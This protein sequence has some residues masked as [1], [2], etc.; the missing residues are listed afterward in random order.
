[1]DREGGIGLLGINVLVF[2][3]V[4][5][6]ATGLTALFAS[7]LLAAIIMFS[8]FSFLAVLIYLMLGAP[9]VAFTEA[10]VGVVATTFLIVALKRMDRGC[11]K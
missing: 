5:M 6:L 10:V 4:L 8:A 3:L 7:D 11:S 2:L 1:L 9:D